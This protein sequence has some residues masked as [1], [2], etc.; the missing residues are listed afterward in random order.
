M[1]FL[2]WAT[3]FA[4]IA[5]GGCLEYRIAYPDRPP[6]PFWA[7]R[8]LPRC[9]GVA[10]SEYPLPPL[11]K[12]DLRLGAQIGGE[13]CLDPD[14]HVADVFVLLSSRRIERRYARH[15]LDREQ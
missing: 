7:T 10:R 9:D 5:R 12:A 13:P 3:S 2:L 8:P 4:V 14:F 6:R 1:G 15:F 11:L